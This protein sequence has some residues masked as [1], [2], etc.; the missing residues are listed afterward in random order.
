MNYLELIGFIQIVLIA[1]TPVVFAGIGELVTEKSGVLNL[2]VEGMMLVGAVTAFVTL[3]ITGSYVLA[4]LFSILAGILMSGLFAFLVLILMSNQ[5][6]TGLSLTI[7]GI[8]LSS[9]IGKKY[10]GT[11]IEG[12]TPWYFVI[13]SFIIVFL[14]GYFFYKTKSGLILRAVGESHT[15]AHALGYSVL[16]IR[17]L[18]ILFG[19][20]MCAFAGSYIS[21][22]YAPMWQEGMIAGRGW[23]A[24]ALVVFSTWKPSR[25]LI[26]AYIF[27]GTSIFQMHLQGKGF[28]FPHW[29]PFDDFF[30][31]APFFNMS[32][33]L[34]TMIVLVIISSNKLR[35]KLSAPACLTMP[36]YKGS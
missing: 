28:K 21:I 20:S 14:V 1:T 19:G 7:F 3:V 29:V 23:I 16:K 35:I 31:S 4:F 32:P 5:V 9:M 18:A 25:I 22:C 33:Y 10:I 15:S 2:G 13:L 17:L 26:G 24:L 34:A 8:G 6:A 12:L 30:S 11:P 36:F 27:G